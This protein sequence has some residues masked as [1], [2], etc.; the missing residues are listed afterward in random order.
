MADLL[1]LL[2]NNTNPPH[3][4]VL[5]VETRRSAQEVGGW[6]NAHKMG[7][8]IAVVY[9]SLKHS[10]T[11]YTQDELE[12]MFIHLQKAELV[13]GFNIIGF[14]YKVLQPFSKYNLLNLPTLDLLV[15]VTKSLSYRV[16]LDN[17]AKATLGLGKNANGMQ[18][19][20]WWKQGRLD[21]ITTYCK[22]DVD[23][24]RQIYLY[25]HKERHIFF[26]NKAGKKS[27][28]NVNF[29]YHYSNK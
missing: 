29:E 18:A 13:I 1:S 9:D 11:A 20:T 26:T 4:M 7:I 2:N 8:S 10:F 27:R 14:D 22:Q 15:Q 21:E 6:G 17:I 25:G 28:V 19:L 24:T 23:V 16:S 3:F 5:D 12:T